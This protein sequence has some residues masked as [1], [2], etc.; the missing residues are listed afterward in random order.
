MKQT[1]TITIGP[2]TY[3][4]T[5]LGARLALDLW[6]DVAKA[7]APVLKGAD[8]QAVAQLAATNPVAGL[9]IILELVE[10]LPKDLVN[11]LRS[12]FAKSTK[13]KAPFDF[14]GGKESPMVTMTDELFDGHFAGRMKAM[15]LWFAECLKVNFADF[16]DE[17]GNSNGKTEKTRTPSASR[18]RP[19]S[20]G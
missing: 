19:G 16:L 17:G 18:S 7:L 8:P 3:E 4:I 20:S 12:E 5:Q 9:E 1:K 2:D 15:G 11:D 6:L 13:I 10:S 14:S